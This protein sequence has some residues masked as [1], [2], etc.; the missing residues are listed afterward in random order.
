MS[1]RILCTGDMHLG[2]RPTQIPEDADLHALRPTATWHSF[3]STAVEL[4]VDAVVLTGDVVDESNKFY[5]AFSALQSGIER[6]VNAGIPVL[7]VSGNHDFDVLP[8]LV[9]QIP[10]FHLLGRGGQWDDFVLEKDGAH[11]M[12]FQGWSFPTRLARSATT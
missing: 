8:R 11:A 2:R 7:A 6:L 1:I 9:D 12:R 10:N 4:R 3:V 5:E